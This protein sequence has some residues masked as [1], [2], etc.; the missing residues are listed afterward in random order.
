M[1]DNLTAI[2]FVAVFVASGA[3]SQWLDYR[4][5]RAEAELEYRRDDDRPGAAG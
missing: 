2:L 5:R 1:G 4:Q 3:W